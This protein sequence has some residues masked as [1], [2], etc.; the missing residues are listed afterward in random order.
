MSKTA[1]AITSWQ[2]MPERGMLS[3]SAA[4]FARKRPRLFGDSPL[5]D[6]YSIPPCTGQRLTDPPTSLIAATPKR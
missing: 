2:Q 3:G 1:A 4:F 5:L 6:H